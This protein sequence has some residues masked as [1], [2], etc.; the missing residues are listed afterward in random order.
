MWGVAEVV[1]REGENGVEAAKDLGRG[2]VDCVCEGVVEVW[3]CAT[4]VDAGETA[5]A[6][7]YGDLL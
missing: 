6:C 1:S 5:P 4:C 2:A 7:C 3:I